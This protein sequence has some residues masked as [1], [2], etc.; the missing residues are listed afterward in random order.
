[1]ASAW[2]APALRHFESVFARAN[3]S[4]ITFLRHDLRGAAAYAR[5]REDGRPL[6]NMPRK[7]RKPADRQK[8]QM[9]ERPFRPVELEQPPTA[10][11]IPV[12]REQQPTEAYFVRRTPTR[13]LPIYQLKKGG[14]TL[15]QT[16]VKKVSGQVLELKRQLEELLVPPPQW[17]RVNPLNNHIEM[18]V[19]PSHRPGRPGPDPEANKVTSCRDNTNSRSRSI[20]SAKDFEMARGLPHCTVR[21]AALSSTTTDTGGELMDVR[22]KSGHAQS[23]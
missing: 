8:E 15:L 22:V 4:R 17:I 11:P 20:C 2:Q 6:K 10:I 5:K 9:Q 21:A 7:S 18:K 19:R 23:P 13:H 3:P 1:M 14:G 12:V 16:R